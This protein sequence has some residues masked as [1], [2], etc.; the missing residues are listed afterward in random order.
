MTASVAVGACGTVSDMPAVVFA[1]VT[2]GVQF[3][4]NGDGEDLRSA[5]R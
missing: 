2:L 5:G 1:A 4:I 3:A